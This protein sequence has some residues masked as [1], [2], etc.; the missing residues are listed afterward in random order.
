M[1]RLMAISTISVFVSGATLSSADDLK[2]VQPETK[3][4]PQY[5][6]FETRIKTD[7]Q[8]TNPFNP[9]EVDLQVH[10]LTPIGATHT[11]PAFYDFVS[12][13]NKELRGKLIEEDG[14]PVWKVRYAPMSVGVHQFRKWTVNPHFRG[15]G[16]L[17]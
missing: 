17:N 4:I 15:K 7:V 6:K 10:F 9:E 13:A 5:G 1:L 14:Q 12:H 11:L 16:L 2:I 8:C 3:S